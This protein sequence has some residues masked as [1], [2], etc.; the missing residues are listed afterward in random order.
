[1]NLA[2]DTRLSGALQALSESENDLLELL[3][4]DRAEIWLSR[5]LEARL[6]RGPRESVQ[7]DVLHAVDQMLIDAVGNPGGRDCAFQRPRWFP[8]TSCSQCGAELGPGTSG[9]SHCRDHGSRRYAA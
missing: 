3:G 1:M 5:I 8:S 2:H 4:R 7:R 6:G 9:V